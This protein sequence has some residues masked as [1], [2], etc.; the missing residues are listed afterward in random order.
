MR[1]VT[2]VRTEIDFDYIVENFLEKELWEKTWRI[3]NYDNTLVI[4]NLEQIDVKRKKIIFKLRVDDFEDEDYEIT[5]FSVPYQKEHR[6]V[7]V[8]KK[9]LDYSIR[10]IYDMLDDNYIRKTKEYKDAIKR[11]DEYKEKLKKRAN[12]I[13][14]EDDVTNEEI[15]RIFVEEYAYENSE[16][17]T[18]DVENKLKW[19][20]MGHVIKTYFSL[21]GNDEEY[22]KICKKQLKFAGA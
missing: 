10:L 16:N 4:M 14:D 12:N 15:R 8:F 17:F 11:E 9:D 6:N 22:E 19:K 5:T 2:P 18:R 13:L 7:T 1:D 3:F 21:V 20:F